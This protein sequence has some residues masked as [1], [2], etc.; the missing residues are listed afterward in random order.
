MCGHVAG[1]MITANRAVG[2]MQHK[3]FFVLRWSEREFAPEPRQLGIGAVGRHDNDRRH[4]AMKT[5]VVGNHANR[6]DQAEQN[7]EL[8]HRD[9]CDAFA[10]I[11]SGSIEAR[12]WRAESTRNCSPRGIAPRVARVP[13]LLAPPSRQTPPSP[14]PGPAHK[15]AP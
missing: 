2:V 12:Y 10:V 5:N 14:C 9:A 3:D 7:E 15:K 13:P 1:A 8:F 11:A 4:R 6:D